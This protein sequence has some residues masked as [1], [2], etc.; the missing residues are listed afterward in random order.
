AADYA[1]SILEEAE[2]ASAE[3]EG[4][5]QDPLYGAADWFAVRMKDG[6]KVTLA[7]QKSSGLILNVSILPQNP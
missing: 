2:V 1:L 4:G 5:Y 7:V 3:Q 6:Y